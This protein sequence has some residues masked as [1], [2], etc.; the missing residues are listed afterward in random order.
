MNNYM[1]R[2]VSLLPCVNKVLERIILK[3]VYN[4]MLDNNVISPHQSGFQPGNS[5]TKQLSVRIVCCDI[6]V[7]PCIKGI[8]WKRLAL[9][10]ACSHFVKIISV[11]GLK[12]WSLING[13]NSMPGIIKP[14][15][16]QGSAFGPLLFLIYINDITEGIESYVKLFADNTTLFID[17][18]DPI[19]AA[20][21]LNRDLKRV[22]EWSSKS[23]VNFNAENTKL[24]TC[25]FRSLNHPD[26]VTVLF[27][28]MD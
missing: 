13:Q 4:F 28:T 9:V 18:D 11:I 6:S 19:Q 20:D 10:G 24:M 1:Y 25:S 17:V 16:P 22:E 21:V 8:S 2:H 7:P 26:I 23:L 15:V 5:T 12:E 3:T 27:E 14:G